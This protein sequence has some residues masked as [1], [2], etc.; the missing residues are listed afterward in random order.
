VS[1]TEPVGVG[2]L[3]QVP[4]LTVTV[5]VRPCVFVMVENDGD[6]IT[7]G[8]IIPAELPV[9]CDVLTPN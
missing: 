8:V 2:L 5:T 1:V 4:A 6:T 3:P 9:P 7:V